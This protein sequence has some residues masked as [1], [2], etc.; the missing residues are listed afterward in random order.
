MYKTTEEIQNLVENQSANF[1]QTIILNSNFGEAYTLALMAIADLNVVCIDTR[2][3][4]AKKITEVDLLTSEYK[5]PNVNFVLNRAGYNPGF[6][7]EIFRTFR[8]L[9]VF[10]TMKLKK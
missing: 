9:I 10:F 4:P 3:T 7:S 2:L 5:L 1:D 6:I 8:K